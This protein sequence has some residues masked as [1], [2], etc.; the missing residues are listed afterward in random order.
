MYIEANGCNGF[1]QAAAEA[2]CEGGEVDWAYEVI[3]DSSFVN[4]PCLYGVYED[5]GKAPTFNNYLQNFEP[6]F[7]VAH[8]R[9]STSTTL[10]ST[11]NA[12]TSAPQNYVI[13][14][15]FNVNNLDRPRLSVART[16]IHE[17]IHAEMF[18]KLLSVAQH[19]SIQLS[20]EQLIQLRND[21]PGLYDYY[22]RWKWEV[23][24]GQ[25]PSSAQH[26]AMAQHY[27]DIIEQALREFDDSHPDELYEALAWIG[28]E[29]TVTWSN[30]SQTE[31]DNIN[32][33][34]TDFNSS[35]S[36]N[37]Q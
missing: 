23:P 7:S 21:F 13:T 28:L 5:M 18:R 35:N 36:D 10:P 30:L 26:Q 37:C 4:N 34:I 33:T 9:L 15:T 27:R 24:E 12:E 20:Q 3:L 25:S 22:K 29:D 2:M 17:M 14:I 6:Q 16:F 32:Q 19:P 8:L 31:R 11:T 1:A